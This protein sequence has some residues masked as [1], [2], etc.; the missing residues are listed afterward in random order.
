MNNTFS[1]GETPQRV[2]LLQTIYRLSQYGPLVPVSEQ[3]GDPY[4]PTFG[5]E[6]IAGAA[7][8]QINL[9]LRQDLDYLR[10]MHL[11]DG[12]GLEDD[13]C[14]VDSVMWITYWGIRAVE[15][16]RPA[17]Q[18]QTLDT[19]VAVAEIVRD[20]W[21]LLG[22]FPDWAISEHARAGIEAMDE[23]QRA[24]LGEVCLGLEALVSPGRRNMDG[25]LKALHELLAEVGE[26]TLNQ[27]AAVR[28]ASG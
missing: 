24:R 14:D 17:E 21:S 20:L 15:A 3:P 10:A 7:G 11:I 2:A 16:S 1:N 23:D 12:S 8:R 18:S 13:Q 6:Q 19:A 28:P 22:E 5:P 25:L 9:Q 4:F 27:T 26:L